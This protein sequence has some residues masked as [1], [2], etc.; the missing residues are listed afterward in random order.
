MRTVCSLRTD[1]GIHHMQAASV[2]REPIGLRETHGLV[3]SAEWWSHIEPGSL[4][5]RTVSGTV[6]RFWPGDHGDWPEFELLESSGARSVWGCLIPA[7]EAALAFQPGSRVEVD[8]V[9]QELKQSF[10]GTHEAKLTV[11]IRVAA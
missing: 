4:L 10:N 11:A 5:L 8:Y 9:H 6:A 1:P 3:G 7:P 2:G